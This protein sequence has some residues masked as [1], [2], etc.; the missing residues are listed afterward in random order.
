MDLSGSPREVILLD[1]AFCPGIRIAQVEL[2]AK[3]VERRR[4][5]EANDMA[6]RDA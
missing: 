6:Q 5:C 1:F 3:G 4:D 2:Q